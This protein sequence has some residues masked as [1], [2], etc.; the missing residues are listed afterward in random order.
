[1]TCCRKT[2]GCDGWMQQ[3]IIFL[4]GFDRV[5]L[6][7]KTLEFEHRGFHK[8]TSSTDYCKAFFLMAKLHFLSIILP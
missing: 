7:C 6:P 1:M 4:L 5:K 8:V 2:E 3:F